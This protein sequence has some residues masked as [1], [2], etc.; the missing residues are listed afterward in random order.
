FVWNQQK[1]CS[2]P[3]NEPD[4]TGSLTLSARRKD[5]L[6]VGLYDLVLLVWLSRAGEMLW[7][8]QKSMG[9]LLS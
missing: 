6:A 8:C 1:L 7:L 3:A 4:L 5:S 9:P 2:I